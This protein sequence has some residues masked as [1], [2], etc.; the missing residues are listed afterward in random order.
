[1]HQLVTMS[2]PERQGLIDDF[3]DEAFGGLD[4]NPELVALLRSMRPELPDDPEPGQVNAWVELAE[5]VQDID[6]RASV[7]RMAE[8]QAAQ[9]AKGDDT[10]LHHDLT[11]RVTQEVEAAIAADI[12]PTSP[13]AAAVVD[14]LIGDY[15]RVFRQTDTAA[16]RAA[17]LQRLEVAA[18]PRAQRYLELLAQING[19]GPQPDL[20]P[21]FDWFTRALRT[22][23]PGAPHAVTNVS[24]DG[25]TQGHRRIDAG[26]RPSRLGRGRMG[27]RIR[28]LPRRAMS[29][30]ERRAFAAVAHPVEAGHRGPYLVLSDHS[31]GRA[32]PWAWRPGGEGGLAR[33]RACEV[34]R[35]T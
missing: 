12:D 23:Q 34:I 29:G 33:N 21:V 14:G 27:A 28:A 25:V 30:P 17:V 11:V 19:W 10:G 1:M 20:A 6:F 31:A 26:H 5:L 13:A 22:R 35:P 4:A 8:F 7:R 16:F 24:L 15:A 32:C 18:D 3:L 9:R 2:E